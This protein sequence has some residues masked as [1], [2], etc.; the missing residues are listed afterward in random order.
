MSKREPELYLLDILIA[1]N[2]IQRYTQKFENPD[3]FLH[4]ELA[5]DATIR[6][7]E[8]IGEATNNLL[9]ENIISTDYRRIVNFRNQIAH[10]YFGIDAGIVLDIS[11]NKIKEYSIYLKSL[12]LNL[13]I[14]INLS[15]KE[16]AHNTHIMK[17]L[18]TLEME[19]K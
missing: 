4:D 10:G 5:W 12:D 3:D 9:K 11:R 1:Q 17:L 15:K 14:A 16:H 18:K 8:I 13:L 7:L 2:K 19:Q 6:E